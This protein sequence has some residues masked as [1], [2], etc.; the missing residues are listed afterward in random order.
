LP[1]DDLIFA[2]IR[3]IGNTWLAPR[4]DNH[5]ANVRP[6]QTTMSIVWVEVGVRIPVVRT[7]STRPPLDRSFHGTCT[8]NCKKVLERLGCIV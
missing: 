6:E 7:V 3:D 4:L 1:P 5:P 8:S 2:K